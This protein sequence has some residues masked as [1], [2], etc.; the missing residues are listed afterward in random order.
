M[1]AE[2][3]LRD[4]LHDAA[5]GVR[6]SADDAAGWADVEARAE[7]SHAAVSRRFRLGLLAAA[8]AVVV[9]LAA[10]AV[11]RDDPAGTRVTPVGP[12]TTTAPPTTVHVPGKVFVG[13]RD[14][15]TKLVL[16]DG[17]TGAGQFVVADLGPYDAAA[18][19]AAHGSNIIDGI[20]TSPDGNWIYF[21]TGP[22][23]V[24]G[25]LHRVRRTGGKIEDLGAGRDP[26]ISPDG[27][28]LAFLREDAVIRRP[29]AG[30]REVPVSVNG[31]TIT[32][33][34]WLA[35]GSLLYQAVNGSTA[36]WYVGGDRKLT[37]AKDFWTSPTAWPGGHVAFIDGG[38]TVVVVDPAA[39]KVV[40]RTP[41]PVP[42]LHVSADADGNQLYIALN[43]ELYRRTG[44][45]PFT[46]LTDNY[47]LTAW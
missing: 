27:K 38:R 12:S 15:S 22:E 11:L 32:E 43:G 28:T 31:A 24:F 39:D 26:E 10:A 16:G 30:G 45:G 18:M 14:H 5:A 1:S 40:S 20:A 2:D 47:D 4:L 34:E 44:S 33:V 41:T 29:V 17:E 42:M 46:R 6:P 8:A 13:S 23:P 37:A 35:D 19:E 36:T 3:R 25:E 21:S 7:E 9:A